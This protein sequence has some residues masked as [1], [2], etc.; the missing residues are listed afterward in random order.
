MA[1]SPIAAR[2]GFGYSRIMTVSY[3]QKQNAAPAIDP[4]QLTQYR[5]RGFCVIDGLYAEGHLRDIEAFFEEYKSSGVAVFDGDSRFEEI[6]K[7]KRQVRAMHPHRH[8]RKA[9]GWALNPNVLDVLETLM[10]KPP[11]LAQTMYYFKPP[12]SKGQGMHQDN[13]Y[14]LA[15]PATCVAAWTPLDDAE[16]ENGCLYAAPGSHRG[17]IHCPDGE[18]TGWMEYGDSHIR[19]F[20]REFKPVPVPVKRGQTLFFG[21]QLIH[22]S[23][24]NRHPSRSRRTFIGHYIDSASEEVSHYYHPVIDRDGNTVSRVREATGGGPCGD[25]AGGGVH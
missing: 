11:L 22:G 5:E 10:G 13:F 18:A 3:T 20:P 24:P 23:G 12:G 1:E 7:T 25:G 8:S 6:D 15:K 4:S 17:K 19:P 21:G 2:G 16:V 9:L 14:L